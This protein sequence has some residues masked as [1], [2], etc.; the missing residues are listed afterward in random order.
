MKTSHNRTGR[1]LVRRGFLARNGESRGVAA[2][3]HSPSGRPSARS[4]R[5]LTQG[6]L[7][8]TD[9]V[10]ATSREAS[11]GRFFCEILPCS[12]LLLPSPKASASECLVE[13]LSHTSN[14]RDCPASENKSRPPR[15]PPCTRCIRR[16]SAHCGTGVML[17]ASQGRLELTGW[18][19]SQT[20]QSKARLQLT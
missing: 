13:D 9:S 5:C 16:P 4:S 20:G 1:L 2:F 14:G 19:L 3:G 15:S 11:T 6:R 18:P 10:N 12:C 7:M 17:R 8:R